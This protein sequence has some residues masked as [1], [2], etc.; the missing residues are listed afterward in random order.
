M[1][2]SAVS[3]AIRTRS[4]HAPGEYE[5]IDMSSLVVGMFFLIAESLIADPFVYGKP[6]SQVRVKGAHT[7]N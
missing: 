1:A 2:G 3:A 5:L 4:F 7:R 6:D